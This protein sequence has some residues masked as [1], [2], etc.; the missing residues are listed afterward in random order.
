VHDHDRPAQVTGDSEQPDRRLQ[1]GAEEDREREL[2]V[3]PRQ[4]RRAPRGE[5]R[6]QRRRDRQR[7]EDAVAELDERVPV[8]RRQRMTLLAPGPVT[9]AEPRVGQPHR[10]AGDDDQPQRRQ[11]GQDERQ[12]RRRRERQ[13]APAR[14]VS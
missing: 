13:R 10:R 1:E 14:D 7:A 5:P 9:A 8:L 4:R 12:Q 6:E 3:P 11:L 2:D